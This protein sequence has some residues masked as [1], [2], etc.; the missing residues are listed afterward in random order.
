MHAA[1]KPAPGSC[2]RQLPLQQHGLRLPV[3]LSR[4]CTA[5]PASPEPD[6][7]ESYCLQTW[8][9][10]VAAYYKT[11]FPNTL[12]TVGEEGFWG[13]YDPQQSK[14]PGNGWAPI[15]G[16]NFTAQ[17]SSRNVDFTA[18]HMWPS[19]WSN[20]VSGVLH[21]Y[22][23]KSPPP[24]NSGCARS[25]NR[26]AARLLNLL[27]PAQQQQALTLWAVDMAM[28]RCLL[29]KGVS[30]PLL[31]GE[32]ALG[33]DFIVQWIDQH[34]IAAA[35]LGKPLIVEEFGV[36]VNNTNDSQDMS[37]RLAIY[38]TAY[39]ALNSSITSSAPGAASILR[40]ERLHS[41]AAPVCMSA[42]AFASFRVA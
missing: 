31:Q 41:V 40:G 35:A 30:S 32:A 33:P 18:I 9:N 27:C 16:N 26:C 2:I 24:P 12:L 1:Q 42:A 17:H 11:V 3:A 4:H 23:H 14:N 34:A 6:C 36:A 21:V 5:T 13:E 22:V 15:T 39:M 20:A 10:N 19:Q 8:I 29:S 37:S 7:R 28:L 38:Q 25:S